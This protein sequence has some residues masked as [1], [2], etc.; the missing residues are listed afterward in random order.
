MINSATDIPPIRP[1]AI[2]TFPTQSVDITP[3]VTDMLRQIE[4]REGSALKS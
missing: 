4:Q 2:G 3:F 1:E